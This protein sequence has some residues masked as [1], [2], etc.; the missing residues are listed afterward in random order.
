MFGESL[1]LSAVL[2]SLKRAD[3]ALNE[4]VAPLWPTVSGVVAWMENGPQLF[5]VDGAPSLPGYYLLVCDG[6]SAKVVQE[7]TTDDA[8][9]YRNYLDRANVILLAN[10]FAY[11]ATFAERLQG[12][13]SPRPIYFAPAEPMLQVVARYDGIN[14]F[15]DRTPGPAVENPLSALFSGNEVFTTGELLDIPG[16]ESIDE[17][18]SSANDLLSDIHQQAEFR[19]KSLLEPLHAE[20]MKWEPREDGFQISWLWH[21]VEHTTR[22]KDLSSPLS[23]GICL[24][25][26]RNFDGSA[27]TRMLL[28]HLL[29]SWI[30]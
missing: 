12:I 10:D 8:Q 1:D 29:D 28:E 22:V 9:R 4:F 3:A 24:A 7:A 14:L 26:A 15:Y 16:E 19:L 20:L 23:S 17:R 30:E 11:P 13:T 2:N 5:T 6:N 25:G 27:L 18:A 21:E